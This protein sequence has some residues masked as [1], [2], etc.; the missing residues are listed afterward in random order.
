MVKEAASTREPVCMY[1]FIN[2]QGSTLTISEGA[3]LHLDVIWSLAWPLLSSES[4]RKNEN[5]KCSLVLSPHHFSHPAD[6]TDVR[7]RR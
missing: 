7:H 4:Q 3:E 2:A 1:T 6:R 5:T